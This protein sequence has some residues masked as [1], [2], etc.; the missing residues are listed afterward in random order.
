MRS[1]LSI[2][3]L[4]RFSSTVFELFRVPS[5][6]DRQTVIDRILRLN[7]EYEILYPDLDY[8]RFAIGSWCNERMDV[9]Q[10]LYNTTL[11]DYDP[12]ANYDRREE[13]TD[14]G[15]TADE[16]ETGET[17]TGSASATDTQSTAGFNTDSPKLHDQ[18]ATTGQSSRNTNVSSTANGSSNSYHEGRVHGNIGVT[19]TQQLITQER[20][21]SEFN[22]IEYIADDFAREFCLLVY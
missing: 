12:I 3:G 14:K 19:S 2:L 15:S 1:R 21:V 22:I 7:A 5:G 20:E 16:R 17:E 9:W 8:M 6:V 10:R 4:Y 13:W 18:G 11:Y